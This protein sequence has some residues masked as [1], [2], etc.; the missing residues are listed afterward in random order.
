MANF[1]GTCY[2]CQ[3][4]SVLQSFPSAKSLSLVSLSLS[5]F[6]IICIV[7]NQSLW[8]ITH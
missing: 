2:Y 6:L 8:L 5:D 3:Y 7:S 1:A 4:W